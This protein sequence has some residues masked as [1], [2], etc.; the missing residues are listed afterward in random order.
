MN[1][2]SSKNRKTVLNRVKEYYENNKEELREKA[3]KK[4]R[5]LTDE[6]TI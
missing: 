2:F 1:N 4:Y 5:E 3:R 6:E